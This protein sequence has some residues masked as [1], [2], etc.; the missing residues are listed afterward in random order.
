MTPGSLIGS[1]Q[2]QQV[3]RQTCRHSICVQL[4][5][6]TIGRVARLLQERTPCTLFLIRYSYD[7]DWNPCFLS[8]ENS[9]HDWDVLPFMICRG[10]NNQDTCTGW[11]EGM[12]DVESVDVGQ[13]Q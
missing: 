1:I 5:I 13:S 12:I 2:L 11:K 7:I 3:L 6:N 4:R 10:G 8:G 9:V